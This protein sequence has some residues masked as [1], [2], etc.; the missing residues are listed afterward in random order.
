MFQGCMTNSGCT[1]IGGQDIHSPQCL[2]IINRSCT[3][4]Q[5]LDSVDPTEWITRWWTTQ[6]SGV[7]ICGDVLSKHLRSFPG[8]DACHIT[9]IRR[10]GLCIPTDDPKEINYEMWEWAQITLNEAVT[11]YEEQGF[12]FNASPDQP[13]YTP[14]TDAVL[15]VCCQNPGLCQGFLRNQCREYSSDAI[16][17]SSTLRRMCGCHMNPLNYQVYSTEYNIPQQCSPLCNTVDAVQLSGV[18]GEP[19]MCDQNVCIIDNTSLT[20]QG[21]TIGGDIK[22]EQICGSSTPGSVSCTVTDDV[23]SVLNSEIGGDLI[24]VLNKCGTITCNKRGTASYCN[25][26]DLLKFD[27]DKKVAEEKSIIRSGT[28]TLLISAIL[29]AIAIIGVLLYRKYG[30]HREESKGSHDR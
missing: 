19:I 5:E 17:K 18:S 28:I 24:P 11:K 20:V 4:S 9:P 27:K 1:E 15:N 13:G 2:D 16:S 26:E 7:P 10:D 30:I 6:E 12:K 25:T 29:I 3:G 8:Y 21:S 22:F 23:I 14:F